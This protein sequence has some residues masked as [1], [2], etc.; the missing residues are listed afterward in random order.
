MTERQWSPRVLKASLGL[1]LCTCDNDFLSRYNVTEISFAIFES[2]EMS[3]AFVDILGKAYF[4]ERARES[5][6]II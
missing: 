4:T 1:E 6:L 5:Q 3:F 2:V